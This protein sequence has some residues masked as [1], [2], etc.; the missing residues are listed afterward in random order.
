MDEALCREHIAKARAELDRSNVDV[1]Y[2]SSA[3][4]NL[5]FTGAAVGPGDRVVALLLTRDGEPS[6]VVPGFEANRIRQDRLVGDIVSWEEHESPFALIADILHEKGL[7]SGRI[8]LDGQTW[9]WVVQGLRE[10]LP[11]VEFVNGEP[12]IN[13]C[14][15]RKNEREI[16]FLEQAC[17]ITAKVL[18]AAVAQF[19]PGMT[20]LEFA[21]VI[22]NNYLE[23]GH[24]SGSLVQSG[25]RASDPH[26]PAGDRPI[27]LGDAVVLDSGCRVEGFCSDISR[28]L[29]VGKVSGE[30]SKAWSVLKDAQQAA[31]DAIRP[32]A[33]CES[34]DATARNWLAER[35][36]GDYFL[37]RLGHGIG[38]E[39][40]EYPYLVG[41]NTLP[42]EPGVTTSVEPGIYVPGKFGMRI[43]DVMVVTDDGC[44]VLSPTAP[45]DMAWS[46]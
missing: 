41:G 39:G 2:V 24:Q 3:A 25:P 1:L 38:I 10:A 13:R 45:R 7:A 19:R 22:S 34:I 30:I 11:Q 15:M 4:N 40:H 17:A 27:V 37:H 28:T 23:R 5:Y 6:L 26:A 46:A 14:R 44:R 32:G 16:G 29:L 18:T 20:E 8:A 31:L 21:E 33:T 12:L 35:G 36:Y 43:E 9:Y 42:L